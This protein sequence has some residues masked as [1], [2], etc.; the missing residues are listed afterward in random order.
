MKK[1]LLILP[2]LALSLGTL[3]GCT[4]DDIKALQDKDAEQDSRLEALEG[5]VASLKSQIAALQAEL[6]AKVQETKND[7]NA[8]IDAANAEI[9]AA[10]AKLVGVS[11]NFAAEKAALQADYEA[12]I[13]AVDDK[14]APYKAEVAQEFEDMAADFEAAL[15]ELADSV[16]GS[17]GDL[18]DEI[19][20]ILAALGD[21]EEMLADF[22]E[23]EVTSFSDAVYY[24]YSMIYQ[25]YQQLQSVNSS[26]TSKINTL[27]TNV[28]ALQNRC[29][30]IESQMAADKAE[31]AQDLEDAVADLEDA[32]A[33]EAQNLQDQIDDLQGLVDD[34][35]DEF[36]EYIL[37][38]QDDYQSQINALTERIAAL[39]DIPSYT[40]TFN[41]NY[42]Y[43][44]GDVAQPIELEVLRGDKI[45]PDFLDPNV[46]TE[47]N[48]PGN[49][50]VGWTYEDTGKEWAFFGYPVTEDMTLN[51]QWQP[52]DEDHHYDFANG[53]VFSREQIDKEGHV[54]YRCSDH[55]DAC[56][57]DVKEKAG[58]LY[59]EDRFTIS[60]DTVITA[61]VAQGRFYVGQEVTLQHA[62]GTLHNHTITGI[63]MFH[64]VVDF[65]VAGDNVGLRFAGTDLARAEVKIGTM[66]CKANEAKLSDRGEC[67]FHLYSEEEA[68]MYSDIGITP[69]HTP[70]FDGYRPSLRLNGAS[71]LI[72]LTNFDAEMC[73]PGDD[74]ICNF[75]ILGVDDASYISVDEEYYV[76]EGGKVVGYI[77]TGEKNLILIQDANVGSDRV[78]VDPISSESNM[79][80]DNPNFVGKFYLHDDDQWWD[81]YDDWNAHGGY[82]EYKRFAGWSRDPNAVVPDFE[83]GTYYESDVSCTM[84]AIWEYYPDLIFNG[85]DDANFAYEDMG[86]EGMAVTGT[87]VQ[88]TLLKVATRVNLDHGT[89]WYDGRISTST[90]LDKIVVNGAPVEEYIG[91]AGDVVTLYL[92]NISETIMSEYLGLSFDNR[93]HVTIS[94]NPAN[95]GRNALGQA[96]RSFEI[97]YGQ[98]IPT[99]DKYVG[100]TRQLL[101]FSADPNATTPKY[102]PG[103]TYRGED[104]VIYAVWGDP[105][106]SFAASDTF[107]IT[108]R[109]TF[110]VCDEVSAD[111]AIS[112][113]LYY[114]AT[115]GTVKNTVCTGLFDPETRQ[116]IKVNGSAISTATAGMT[117]VGVLVRGVEISN[118]QVGTLCWAK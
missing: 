77:Y 41:L 23:V 1:K 116:P 39:E 2:L 31:L 40:V 90:Y 114:Q 96:L 51:A 91:E 32:L 89:D 36:N 87:L 48:R 113:Q 44:N 94:A 80:F 86:T 82:P 109:G 8:K 24:L 105:I 50:L 25:V 108:G 88:S 83:S 29:A 6:A 56:Y 99:F 117:N 66:L 61:K 79:L 5:D 81:N 92:R 60:G 52:N 63:E 53:F 7:Y 46:Y 74:V 65:A 68:E 28:T 62:D 10:Q 95:G 103:D 97:V 59:V 72:E 118:V 9:A 55:G 22:A 43:F 102:Y 100:P 111:I 75:K 76:I 11:S 78:F 18:Q 70:V 37:L 15:A 30:A 19:D 67:I 47:L 35:T 69:R 14:F 27:N 26:L 12:K 107:V 54:R 101:G 17:E 4:K 3:S 57:L 106:F 110:L 38:L 84:Y 16:G 58:L 49:N 45:D 112:A 20:A 93:L 42:D 115:D 85:I 64:K 104:E 34:L 98:V 21:Y 13:K 71:R 73:M 33:A